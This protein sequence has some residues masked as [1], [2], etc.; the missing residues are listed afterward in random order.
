MLVRLR[1][2][3]NMQLPKSKDPTE[4]THSYWYPFLRMVPLEHFNILKLKHE[5]LYKLVKVERC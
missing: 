1:V 5:K 2:E 4:Y 3:P